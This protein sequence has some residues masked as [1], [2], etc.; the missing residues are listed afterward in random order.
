MIFIKKK[1]KKSRQ[2]QE[3]FFFF[4][5]VSLPIHKENFMCEKR[6]KT[7]FRSLHSF[8]KQGQYIASQLEDFSQRSID[9]VRE[10]LIEVRQHSNN[11]NPQQLKL[12]PKMLEY[13]IWEN[14]T[15]HCM[16]G[17][18]QYHFEAL[19]V[20]KIVMGKGRCCSPKC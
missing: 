20:N 4:C 6:F 11:I 5:F 10:K 8:L 3:N 18:F 17:Y 13:L 16:D 15:Q 7:L 14:W 19:G 2:D 9:H 12:L 1:K